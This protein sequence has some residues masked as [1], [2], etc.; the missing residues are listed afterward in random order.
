VFLGIYFKVKSRIDMAFLQ[1]QEFIPGISI[2]GMGPHRA[3]LVFD[4]VTPESRDRL[5]RL[6]IIIAFDTLINNSDR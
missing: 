1:V 5:I 3:A 4:H 6:G 2:S